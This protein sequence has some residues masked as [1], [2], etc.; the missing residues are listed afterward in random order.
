VKIVA[1]GG[2]LRSGVPAALE[3]LG[4]TVE[5]ATL[6]AADYLVAAGIRCREEDSR[7]SSSVDRDGAPVDSAAVLPGRVRSHVSSRRG[8]RSR[9]W[10]S[11]RWGCPR[12]VARDRR[13][14]RNRRAL[15]RRTRFGRLAH[16]DRRPSTKIARRWGHESSSVPEGGES[17]LAS[18]RDSRN[19]TT[20]RGGSSGSLR[21][22]P[23]SC[24]RRS[25]RNRR[26]SGHW[27]AASSDAL[28]RP[29]RPYLAL[30]RSR[31]SAA[32]PRTP[33]SKPASPEVSA[34]PARIGRS[35]GT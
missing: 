14:R 2:E 29:S 15:R 35:R 32:R 22:G 16:E 23:R 21:F 25:S 33:S 6:P 31:G 7:R 28:P 1:D 10:L 4:A 34:S 13:S 17:S 5:R 9:S 12:R 8:Q 3:R 30:P 24:K 18:S 26:D 27:P 20:Y 11:Q 19:R